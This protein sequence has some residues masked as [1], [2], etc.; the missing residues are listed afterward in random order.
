MLQICSTVPGS[1]NV[2]VLTKETSIF[3]PLCGVRKPRLRLA[4]GEVLL[5]PAFCPRQQSKREGKAVAEPPH[6]TSH[7]LPNYMACTP[8]PAERGCTTFFLLSG[9]GVRGSLLA[10]RISLPA[11]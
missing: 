1:R 4:F 8:V 5:R 10:S 2:L 9:I 11:S 6:S 3:A 7:T